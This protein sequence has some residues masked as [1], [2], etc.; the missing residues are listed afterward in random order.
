VLVQQ[1]DCLRDCPRFGCPGFLGRVW[2]YGD[3]TNSHL[4]GYICFMARRYSIADA[5][6]KL[7][8]L[9]H[10]AEAGQA[11]ELTRRGKPVAVVVSINDYAQLS[12]KAPRLTGRV[13]EFRAKYLD[14]DLGDVFDGLRDRAAGRHVEIER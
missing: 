11:V 4:D 7:P 8:R 10:E 2:P 14:E 1:V 6:N 3:L 12:G 9:V 5:R 13:A